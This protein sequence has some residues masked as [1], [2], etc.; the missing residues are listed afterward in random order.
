[1]AGL[2]DPIIRNR[3]AINKT[4]TRNNEDAQGPDVRP[5]KS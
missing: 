1:M 5:V 2:K 3:R 4:F